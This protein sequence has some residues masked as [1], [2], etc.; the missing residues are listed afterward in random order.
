[1]GRGGGEWREVSGAMKEEV[2]GRGGR[3]ELRGE[4]ESHGTLR[5]YCE[6]QQWWQSGSR[7]A[8][9]VESEGEKKRVQYSPSTKVSATESLALPMYTSFCH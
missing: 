9:E 5:I 4:S 2:R 6:E 3:R 8:E 7:Y 1:M